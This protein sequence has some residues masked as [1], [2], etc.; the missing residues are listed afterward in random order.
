MATVMWWCWILIVFS[1]CEPIRAPH[2]AQRP[3][4]YTKLNEAP[5]PMKA[6][7]DDSVTVYQTKVPDA[8]YVEV[9][10]IANIDG[11]E[12]DAIFKLKR[13]AATIGCDGLVLHGSRTE[14]VGS[15]SSLPLSTGG[16]VAVSKVSVTGICIMFVEDPGSWREPVQRDECE[17]GR[18]RIAAT[19]SPEEK[20]RLIRDLPPECHKTP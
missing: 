18:E 1:A 13:S 14:E 9:A 19:P 6:R 5:R 20:Y 7:A 16:G 12:N 15:S 11:T 8:A 4:R 17:V 3:E 2:R 10:L